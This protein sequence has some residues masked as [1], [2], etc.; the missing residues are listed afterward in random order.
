MS[1]EQLK[2]G[3]LYLRPRSYNLPRYAASH[4]KAMNGFPA[5][6][7]FAEWSHEGE[8]LKYDK[9]RIYH[10]HCKSVSQRMPT[11]D[12]KIVAELHDAIENRV[13][14]ILGSNPGAEDEELLIFCIHEEIQ[15]YFK[16]C[17]TSI[18]HLR[19][20]I[21]VLTKRVAG[22]KS[23]ERVDALAA[24]V[25]YRRQLIEIRKAEVRR[26]H[27]RIADDELDVLI[28]EIDRHSPAVSA[29]D[30]M[31]EHIKDK[32]YDEYIDN[33]IRDAYARNSLIAVAVKLSDLMDNSDPERNPKGQNIKYSDRRRLARYARA[34][35]RIL[36]EFPQIRLLDPDGRF[37]VLAAKGELSRK[38]RRAARSIWQRKRDALRGLQP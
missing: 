10:T 14:E 3:K 35:E 37:G 17:G 32:D 19:P 28:G 22:T 25:E 27:S 31:W 9:L 36:N 29:K 38:D 18:E 4:H 20:E 8:T 1:L 15:D 7:I 5:A 11:N 13:K 6:I 24:Q 23:S 21:D 30:I 12:E 33:L 26:G 16:N 34:Q 2:D